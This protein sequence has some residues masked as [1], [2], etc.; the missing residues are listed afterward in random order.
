M[1]FKQNNNPFKRF[2]NSPGQPSTPS[3][4]SA[5]Q[6]YLD[7][8]TAEI[9]R[10]R[11]QKQEIISA[12]TPDINVGSSSGGVDWEK[13]D[14]GRRQRAAETAKYGTDM[15][16]R[17]RRKLRRQNKRLERQQSRQQRKRTQGGFFSR[18][19]G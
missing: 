10:N 18:L 17:D 9:R 14:T 4:A 5:G 11:E 2:V 13:V 12:N 8:L 7:H 6:G 15:S 1:A 19:F 3:G 16:E